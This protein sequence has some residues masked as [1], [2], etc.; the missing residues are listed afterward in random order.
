MA[1]SQRLDSILDSFSNLNDSV[2]FNGYLSYKAQTL[3]HQKER[4][5]KPKFKGVQTVELGLCLQGQPEHR[6]ASFVT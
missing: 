1:I 2:P 6:T 5:R 4:L 3:I